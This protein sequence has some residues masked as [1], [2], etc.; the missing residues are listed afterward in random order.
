MTNEELL[1]TIE[2]QKAQMK[3]MKELI[4]FQYMTLGF[5]GTRY[6]YETFIFNP[7]TKISELNIM[8]DGGFDAREAILKAK[9]LGLTPDECHPPAYTSPKL[10]DYKTR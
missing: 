4:R 3:K 5:Y 6:N 8:V 1:Q 2:D 9:E 7:F 10:A